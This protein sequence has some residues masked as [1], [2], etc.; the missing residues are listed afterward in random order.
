MRQAH[1]A[2]E[3]LFVDYAEQT[4]ELVDGSTALG[5]FELH[6][7]RSEL[8]AELAGL[9]RLHARALAFLGGV[10]GQIVPDN[11]RAGVLRGKRRVEPTLRAAVMV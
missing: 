5:A 7:R 10:P 6:L 3:R 11:L 1:A 4:V 9:D 2:L 8:D